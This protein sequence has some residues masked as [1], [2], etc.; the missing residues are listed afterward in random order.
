VCVCVNLASPQH[1]GIEWLGVSRN[2][3]VDLNYFN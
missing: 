3:Y 1:S 2:Y